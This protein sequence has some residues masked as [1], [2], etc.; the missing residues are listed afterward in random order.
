MALVFGSL[1]DPAFEGLDLLRRDLLAGVGGGHPHTRVARQ[2]S[3]D[4][5]TLGRLSRHDRNGSR[6]DRL[7]SDLW[8]VQSQPG[9][10][11]SLVRAVTLEAGVRQDRPDVAI[12][13][14]SIGRRSHAGQQQNDGKCECT[15]HGG[16]VIWKNS[17]STP[18]R[19]VGE[20]LQSNPATATVCRYDL[21]RLR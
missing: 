21:S 13:G 4:E 8:D 2:Q 9:L 12:E 16:H 20:A 7:E 1:G 15:F 14:D 6:F 17:R 5:F 19:S 11:L 3:L 18:T 10:A